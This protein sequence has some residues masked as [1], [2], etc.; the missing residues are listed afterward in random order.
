MV[1][2]CFDGWRLSSSVTLL[3]CGPV[4]CWVRWNAAYERCRRSGGRRCTTGQYGYISLGQHLVCSPHFI[5]QVAFIA[6]T[7]LIEWLPVSIKR[8]SVTSKGYVLVRHWVTSEKNDG[9]TKWVRDFTYLEGLCPCPMLV[10][11]SLFEFLTVSD[12][13]QFIFVVTG[14]PTHTV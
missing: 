10:Q 9:E 14:P 1:Q 2:Y 11:C 3:A 7:L 5:L 13:F 4:G 8:A 6:L 12:V